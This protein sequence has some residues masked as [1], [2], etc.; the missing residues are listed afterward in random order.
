MIKAIEKT[1]KIKVIT[2]GDNMLRYF[3][4]D[5]YI[6]N[7]GGNTLPDCAD[8]YLEWNDP[9]IF[10]FV[11]EMTAEEKAV[12]DLSETDKLIADKIVDFKANS[13]REISG[14]EWLR[15]RHNDE[16]ALIAGG[17]DLEMSLTDAEYLAKLWEIY[18]IR[19]KTNDKENLIKDKKAKDKEYIKSITWDSDQS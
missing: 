10:D 12:A 6:I 8:K 13:K 19:K 14:M 11:I 16:K 17:Y 2:V 15:S 3:N 18:N 4:N 9:E 1:G 5:K 7:N